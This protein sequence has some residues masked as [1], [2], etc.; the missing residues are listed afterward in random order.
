MSEKIRHTLQNHEV[1]PPPAAW[2]FILAEL[3]E[4]DQLKHVGQ[5]L[6]NAAVV[7]PA[8]NWNK[9]LSALEEISIG[10]QLAETEVPP[11]AGTWNRIARE[12]NTEES[13]SA[14]KITPWWRYAAAAA[15][16]ITAGLGI[17]RLT[18]PAAMNEE[19][20]LHSDSIQRTDRVKTD[21]RSEA[22]EEIVS[23][24]PQTNEEARND[25][26]LEASK[27]TYARL[28]YPAKKIAREVSAFY[29]N[30]FPSSVTSRGLDDPE[31]TAPATSKAER[32]ITLMT[33]EGNIIR[34]S[35]K[36]G[37]MVCCISGEAEDPACTDQLKKWREKIVAS[38]LG[39]SADSFFEL[40]QLV[41]AAEE[42]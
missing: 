32:Y 6:G 18:R 5:Q 22:L 19:M 35:K 1:S 17:F 7:P 2:P 34:V 30:A 23:L 33:P 36:L 10:R 28:E 11:P 12:L 9:L 42:N 41:N 8:E 27:K 15:I 37:G 24:A 13:S 21:Q 38:P 31:T 40:L 39:H 14:K 20:A 3:N 26:A 16:L 25:A 29:F 4:Q